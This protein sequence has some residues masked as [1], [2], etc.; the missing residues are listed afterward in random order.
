MQLRLYYCNFFPTTVIFFLHAPCGNQLR[1]TGLAWVNKVFLSIYLTVTTVKML[2]S[3]LNLINTLRLKND[4][5]YVIL[6]ISPHIIL[7]T[8]HNFC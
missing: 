3:G 1:L 7:V 8:K 4:E 5:S 6:F 2:R